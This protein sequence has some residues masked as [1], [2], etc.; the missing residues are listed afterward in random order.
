MNEF[1]QKDISYK[2][3]FFPCVRK[4]TILRNIN[5]F[6]ENEAQRKRKKTKLTSLDCEKVISAMPVALSRQDYLFFL[7][8]RA[9]IPLQVLSWLPL[10]IISLFLL[11][12]SDE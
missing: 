7:Q 10:E 3:T 4:A 5:F 9:Y 2:A 11:V 8:N 6:G 1:F 12:G